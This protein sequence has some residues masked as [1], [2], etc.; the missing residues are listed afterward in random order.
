MPVVRT[1][2]GRAR[3][4]YVA[5]SGSYLATTPGALVE[6]ETVTFGD[7]R[8]RR[9]KLLV[10][11][12]VRTSKWGGPGFSMSELADTYAVLVSHWRSPPKGD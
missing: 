8:F 4:S 5:E 7:I 2:N 10:S 6:D 3:C 12:T 9:G 11:F 1:T